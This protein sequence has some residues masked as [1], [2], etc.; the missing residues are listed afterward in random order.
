MST[1]HLL[2][3]PLTTNLQR[4]GAGGRRGQAKTR[5]GESERRDRRK[6]WDARERS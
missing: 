5:E 4:I 3:S 6:V 1:D 2:Q